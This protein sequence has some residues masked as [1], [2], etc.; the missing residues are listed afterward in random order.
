V[1]ASGSATATGNSL[2]W[3]RAQIPSA[4]GFGNAR[5]V[6]AVQSVLAC[7][8]TARGV[9]LLS[10]A[11]CALAGQ[12][13]YRGVDQ[14]LGATM[15]YGI[16]DRSYG[17]GGWGGSLV[18]VDPEARMTVSYVMN[19]MLDQAIGD[20]RALGIVAAAYEGLG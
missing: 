10:P 7:G 11:G 4:S 2:A 1:A 3:R 9:R 16:F 6:A 17:W 19:Q 12:E 18:L 8:G 13:Q 14:I 20:Y 15:R 5:S